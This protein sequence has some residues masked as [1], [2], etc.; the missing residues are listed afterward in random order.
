MQ[1]PSSAIWTGLFCKEVNIGQQREDANEKLM[2]NHAA[3]RPRTCMNH[4]RAAR[5]AVDKGGSDSS[6]ADLT[7]SR[8][9]LFNDIKRRLRRRVQGRVAL[10]ARVAR[11]APQRRPGR[12]RAPRRRAAD[13]R[14]D[15]RICISLIT[16]IGI[17]YH[18]RHPGFTPAR[19]PRSPCRRPPVG[20][21]AALV[22][23][24]RGAWF[25]ELWSSCVSRGGREDGR[26]GR[27]APRGGG[28]PDRTPH[29]RAAESAPPGARPRAPGAR[30]AVRGSRAGAIEP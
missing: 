26:A 15:T 2:L 9:A 27:G 5:A 12:P 29:T 24:F 8:T 25:V 21:W 22:Y 23:R 6:D 7:R 1:G 4:D 19:T 10:A 13:P 17:V 3:R 18:T 30:G 14:S 28:W 11:V 16:N 20:R